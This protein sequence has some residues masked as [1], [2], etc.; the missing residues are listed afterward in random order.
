MKKCI[1]VISLAASAVIFSANAA[2]A[3]DPNVTP[4][5]AAVPE[6][7]TLLLLGAGLIGLLAL[8]RKRFKK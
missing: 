5:P 2:L 3:F 6:P 1:T 7:G 4:P 8:N